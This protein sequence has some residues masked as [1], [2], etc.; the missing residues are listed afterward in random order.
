MDYLCSRSEFFRAMNLDTGIRPLFVRPPEDFIRHFD[1]VLPFSTEWTDDP[2]RIREGE[3][4]DLIILWPEG[5]LQPQEIRAFMKK[6]N[7]N[8]RLW[9]ALNNTVE[10]KD[11]KRGL[12]DSGIFLDTEHLLLCFEYE[13]HKVDVKRSSTE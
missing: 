3:S 11:P 10:G 7:D 4:F 1:K 12:E 9:A 13:L 8:G 2:A 5:E 6:L